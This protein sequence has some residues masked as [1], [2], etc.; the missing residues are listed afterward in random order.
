MQDLLGG[1]RDR[2]EHRAAE[3]FV[4]EP[5]DEVGAA[6]I[7]E[8]QPFTQPERRAGELLHPRLLRGHRGPLPPEPAEW[9]RVGIL[10]RHEH[11]NLRDDRLSLENRLRRRPAVIRVALLDDRIEMHVLVLQRVHQLV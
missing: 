4:P 7:R 9:E 3:I 10:F 1:P 11:R 8:N 2:V 5:D 6:E